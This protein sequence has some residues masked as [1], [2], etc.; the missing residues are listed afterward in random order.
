MAYNNTIMKTTGRK[1]AIISGG[2]SG[3]GSHCALYLAKI[4]IAVY[5]FSRHD[6]YQENVTHIAC[7]VTKAEE[8]KS[9]IETV[10][11]KEGRL[12][13]LI[14]CAGYGISGAIEF[15]TEEDAKRQMEVNFF[16]MDNMVRSAIPYLRE[17]RGSIVTVSSVAAMAAIPFQAYYSASKAAI[18]AY[19]L[20]LTNELKPF[21]IAVTAIMPGDTKTNFT[22][23]R[24]KN[25][26]GNE[27]YSERIA[28]SVSKMEKDERN[29]KSAKEAGELI[30][31][32]A[33]SHT[34]KPVIT[35]GASYQFIIFLLKILPFRFSNA[36]IYRLYAK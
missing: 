8:V 19:T 9:G 10:M 29:G 30:A 23:A 6:V 20:A 25:L 1:V 24:K 2:S 15:T 26:N 3:I 18:N 31:S 21:G 27:L 4:G 32:V 12:D 13:M 34:N 35:I 28:R 16:G 22:A 11:E 5:E 17:S 36:L 7:D 33:L 14:C